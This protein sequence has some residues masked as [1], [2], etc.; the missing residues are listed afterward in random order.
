VPRSGW[1][2]FE[3]LETFV[4]V[5]DNDG[6]A[7][8][9]ARQLG[10]NQASMSKRL[11]QLH[12]VGPLIRRPWLA[13]VGKRWQLTDEGRKLLPAAQDLV[14]RYDRLRDALEDAT[15]G[16]PPV[17][18]ACG[19]QTVTGFVCD[20]VAQMQRRHPEVRLRI[21]T[22]RGRARVEGVVNGALD[23]AVVG[24]RPEAIEQVAGRPLYVEPL[25]KDPLVLVAG[26]GLKAVWARRFAEL[27]EDGVRAEQAAGFP[28]IL[29]EPDADARR[30]LERTFRAAGVRDQLEVVLEIGGWPAVLAYAR[31]GIGAGIVPR[32]A[33]AQARERFWQR[34]LDARQFPPLVTHLIC[35]R[36]PGSPPQPDLTP[37]AALFA[38]LL[39]EAARR[40]HETHEKHEKR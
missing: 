1:L 10:I 12:N 23:L 26:R 2:S 21:A 5:I 17:T 32:S 36:Q 27:P 39:R 15:P 13:R 31:R 4:R 6:R 35:R 11:A 34:P 40:V 28:L 20:A 3:L 22:L 9:T 19:Q 14:R 33:L 18:F 24:H 38:G 16:P 29:P 7:S 37:Q 30:Q 8:V 25:F